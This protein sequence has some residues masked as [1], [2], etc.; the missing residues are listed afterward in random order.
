MRSCIFSSGLATRKSG[1][2]PNKFEHDKNGDRQAGGK[3]R[4]ADGVRRFQR[5]D[6]ERPNPSKAWKTSQGGKEEQGRD[7][8]RPSERT[9]GR[10]PLTGDV[11]MKS[12]FS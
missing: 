2:P 10:A 1:S 4:E 6:G 8:D 7:S 12:N 5:L 9:R 11:G 3:N